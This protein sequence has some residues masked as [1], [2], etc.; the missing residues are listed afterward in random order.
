[1]PDYLPTDF[2]ETVKTLLENME[3]FFPDPKIRN[4]ATEML[5]RAQNTGRNQELD[6]NRY[7]SF[8][9]R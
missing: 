2:N 5:K 6:F 1:M 7:S 8:T 3:T 9:F 4:E